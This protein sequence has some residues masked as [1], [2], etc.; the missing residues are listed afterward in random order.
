MHKTCQFAGC[1]KF[2]KTFFNHCQYHIS[3]R[4]T[5]YKFC[6]NCLKKVKTTDWSTHLKCRSHLLRENK[7]TLLNLVEETGIV[8]IIITM[9]REMERI[10]FRGEC[11][12]CKNTNSYLSKSMLENSQ[13]ESGKIKH[14]EYSCMECGEQ[15]CNKCT[16]DQR[17]VS[18]LS[19]TWSKNCG[20]CL[21]CNRKFCIGC[22]K[23]Y[24]REEIRCNCLS[25]KISIGILTC[26]EMR[27]NNWTFCKKPVGDWI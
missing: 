12:C 19:I 14:K 18:G 3:E 17:C 8:D 5:T 7:D 25:K 2:C 24:Y 9:K 10:F 4:N 13:Y 16:S 6:K 26:L 20:E 23:K 15:I 27:G 21:D 1:T 11:V 22:L